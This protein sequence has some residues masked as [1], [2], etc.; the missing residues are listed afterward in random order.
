MV[1]VT[2]HR[3]GNA[4]AYSFIAPAGN[5]SGTAPVMHTLCGHKTDSLATTIPC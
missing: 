1:V 5:D 3:A 2:L 4:E